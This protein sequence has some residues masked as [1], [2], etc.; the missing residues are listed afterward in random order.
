MGALITKDEALTT[1]LRFL[2][3]GVQLLEY[4]TDIIDAY[5]SANCT[6]N[7]INCTEI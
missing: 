5:L 6:G 7:K 3:N 1:R 4:Y 2:Q